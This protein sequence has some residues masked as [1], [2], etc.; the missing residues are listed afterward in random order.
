MPLLVVLLFIIAAQLIARID[1]GYIEHLLFREPAVKAGMMMG[2]YSTGLD[3]DLADMDVIDPG[4]RLKMTILP[5]LL[6]VVPT[7]IG[8]IFTAVFPTLV[9]VWSFLTGVYVAALPFLIKIYLHFSGNT[10]QGSSMTIGEKLVLLLSSIL[11]GV[12]LILT[13]KMGLT[14]AYVFR[15]IRFKYW[16]WWLFFALIFIVG[17]WSA[18]AVSRLGRRISK[19]FTS[20]HFEMKANEHSILY[21][22]SFKDDLINVEVPVGMAEWDWNTG[23]RGVLWPKIT[24]D[25]MVSNIASSTI[26]DLIAVGRPG[27]ILP[28]AGAVHAY[29]AND[30][31]KESIRLTALR[32]GGIILTVGKTESLQWEISQ[33][34]KL[35][36]LSKCLFLIP[37]KG[38]KEVKARVQAAFKQ[39][40]VNQD[41]YDT[42]A[43][44][45]VMALTG[46]QV[47][48]DGS[49][50]WYW[51]FGRD[52]S[53]YFY[54]ISAFHTRLNLP[55]REETISL[56]T[57]QPDTSQK[58]PEP[59][60]IVPN[61]QTTSN[62][63]EEES[64]PESS[65]SAARLKAFRSVQA[66]NTNNLDTY[67]IQQEP[68]L[69]KTI[70]STTKIWSETLLGYW[71]DA[72][73]E[74]AQKLQR[75]EKAHSSSGSSKAQNSHDVKT[76]C[77]V[78]L[79]YNQLVAEYHSQ[80]DY[81][82]DF[83]ALANRLIDT[84]H[85]APRYV[86]TSPMD[87]KKAIIVETQ[88]YGYIANFAK[89]KLNDHAVEVDAYEKQVE[90][91]RRTQDRRI[92][93]TTEMNLYEALTDPHRQIGIAESM[94]Q[95][96]INL[97]DV[98]LQG[99]AHFCLALSLAKQNLDNTEW[100]TEF[101][102]AY[103]CFHNCGEQENAKKALAYLEHYSKEQ[104]LKISEL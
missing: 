85:I 22:R 38:E 59:K 1:R 36:I 80:K 79:L 76:Q 53:A 54:T 65:F 34:K 97:S 87:T 92:L 15:H 32:S 62:T 29:Y 24:F 5:S 61:L 82:Q 46:F 7:A 23:L 50:H 86:W 103:E 26:N 12:L 69:R 91:A 63:Q 55:S 35:N 44:A 73:E 90:I 10:P 45:P 18:Y 99:K 67:Q 74:Y 98:P 37:P 9:W 71:D 40:G 42:L 66:Q 13:F 70:L 16:V 57:S 56:G 2:V 101:H 60:L 25:E 64:T 4:R 6:L 48:S 43:T 20:P 17:L 77:L 78:Y 72:A 68:M 95:S 49:I 89:Y 14:S 47:N 102:N 88:V 31:W 11:S 100:E 3:A 8:Y 30:K 51:S 58:I 81:T 33:L 83:L 104:K 27:E 52:W 21:L 39:L 75:F 93:F 28:R 94:L 41:E 96:A 84:L 19:L